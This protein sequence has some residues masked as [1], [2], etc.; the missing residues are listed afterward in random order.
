MTDAID[1]LIAIRE[2]L[3]ARIKEA[4]ALAEKL[5]VERTDLELRLVLA[6]ALAALDVSAPYLRHQGPRSQVAGARNQI[7]KVLAA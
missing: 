2:R 7:R 6:N 5:E 4:A 3:D 1:A